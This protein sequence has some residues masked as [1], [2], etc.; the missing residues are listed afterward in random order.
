MKYL[1]NFVTAANAVI[2]SD[3]LIYLLLAVG[4]YFSVR[5][6]F[7]QVT[8]IKEMVTAMFKRNK[9]SAGISSFQALAMSLSG[10]VG[11]GNIAGVATAIF[12]GGPGA[13]FWM[14]LVAFLGAGSAFIESTL[15]Q[16]YKRNEKGQYRGGPAF[17]I[18]KGIKNKRVAK[19]YAIV[20]AI[21]TIL[22]TGLLLPGVQANSIASAVNNAFGVDH[23][24]TGIFLVALLG[25]IIF[26][27]IKTIARV[28]EYVVP[29]MAVAYVLLALIVMVI[30]F[31]KLPEVLGLI[32]SS[33]FGLHATFG[34]IVG[35]MI[36]MG[37][38]RGVYSNEAGQG[39]GPHSAAAAEVTHPVNQ[40]LVQAFSV[41]ID[42]LFVCS[43]TAFM[44]LS[45]GM[46]NVKGPGEELIV[47]NGV[48]Y[49]QDG[50][51]HVDGSAVYTQAAVDKAFS[52]QESFDIAYSG[53]GSY[54]VAIALFFFAFTTLMAYYYIAE[55]NIAY[56]T[57]KRG[58]PLL[59]FALKIGI[60]IAV[61]VGCIRTAELAWSLG[62]LGVGLMAW[63]NIIAILI[64][65]K[66]ALIAF[67]D[68]KEQK[69]ARTQ[70]VFDPVRLGIADADFWVKVYQEKQKEKDASRSETR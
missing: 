65:Q 7:F 14:W 40:G 45:T 15:A 18:E 64:L 9:S 68:Y 59:M 5:M 39:T 63:L 28:A 53:P 34:G 13:V 62:D 12:L 37:V 70:P 20:F 38:K 61:F 17:Y 56:L 66:P 1:E 30:N 44:I 42:T 36:S 41:Y 51:K 48:Y 58:G 6:R 25:L 21:V 55:T 19:I 8:M 60:L 57:H 46:Y 29:F 26:G 67:K 4:V 50:T 2:W 27:G 32:F 10:R 33:A 47:D 22:A 24:W 16:I 11:T 43:A 35:A 49:V 52:G 31:S 3:A 54:T 23:S 69:K